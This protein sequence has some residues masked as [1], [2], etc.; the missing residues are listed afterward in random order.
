MIESRMDFGW[1]KLGVT[2]GARRGARVGYRYP[3]GVW[4]SWKGGFEGGAGG[5]R[6]GARGRAEWRV[7]IAPIGVADE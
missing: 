1:G 6:A 7:W 3:V 5:L 4:Q 2:S